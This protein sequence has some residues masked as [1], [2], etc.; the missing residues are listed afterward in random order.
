[1]WSKKLTP[2]PK[3]IVTLSYAGIGSC[4]SVKLLIGTVFGIPKS[5]NSFYCRFLSAIEN[6]IPKDE[7]WPIFIGAE[8]IDKIPGPRPWQLTRKSGFRCFESF[9]VRIWNYIISSQSAAQ[10]SSTLSDTFWAKIQGIPAPDLIFRNI[11]TVR[12]VLATSSHPCYNQVH[13]TSFGAIRISERGI[14]RR[15]A[16]IQNSGNKDSV[17]RD[18]SVAR[19]VYYSKRGADIEPS[20]RLLFIYT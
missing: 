17:S 7:S 14:L 10:I 20:N 11:I 1:M 12:A 9:W 13:S 18:L 16:F 4:P 6:G 19:C 2:Q 15:Q 3:W 5:E 8:Q